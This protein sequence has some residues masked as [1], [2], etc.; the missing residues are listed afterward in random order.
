MIVQNTS[1]GRGFAIC[2]G[3]MSPNE[4]TEMPNNDDKYLYLIYDYRSISEI[5]LCY[6]ETTKFDA[7]CGCGGNVIEACYDL[8]SA[9]DAC[10]TCNIS[11]ALNI[12]V[13]SIGCHQACV[14]CN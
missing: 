5:P 11:F 10:C 12:C 2:T 1:L 9:V 7:C 8:D 4:T 3:G 14:A 6:S 13:S